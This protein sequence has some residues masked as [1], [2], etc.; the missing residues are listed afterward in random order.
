[1]FIL[2]KLNILLMHKYFYIGLFLALIFNSCKKETIVAKNEKNIVEYVADT[3]IIS[4]NNIPPDTMPSDLQVENFINRVYISLLG[5]KP[6]NIELIQIEN[7]VSETKFSSSDRKLLIEF[8]LL[9]TVEFHHKIY[10]ENSKKLLQNIDTNSINDQ[11]FA[12]Q[13][14]LLNSSLEY[15]WDYAQYELDRLQTLKHEYSNFIGGLSNVIEVQK[16]MVNNYF[17]DQINMGTENFVTSTFLHFLNRYPTQSELYESKQ[18]VDGFSGILFFE[19]GT[20]KNDYIS[21]FFNSESYFEGQI[22]ELFQK[23]LLRQPNLLETETYTQQYKTEKNLK[24]I[25][26]KILSMPEFAGYES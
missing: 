23:Y 15:L 22:R 5:R 24:N 14:I 17:Y 10:E 26:I 11:V 13:L 1:M 7:I 20:T 9:N 2:A 19:L 12:L 4:G 8:A 16:S 3:I 18:M 6:N 21:I 25:L